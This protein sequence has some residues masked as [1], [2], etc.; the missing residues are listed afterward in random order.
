MYRET[1]ETKVKIQ[2]ANE[3]KVNTGIGFFDHMLTL[4]CFQS[5]LQ[6]DIEAKGDLYVDN[7]HTME[8]VGIVL[9]QVIKEKLGDRIGI[10]R[11]GNAFVPMDETLA[12]VTLDISNRPFLVFNM[13]IANEDIEEFFRAVAFNMGIT[14]HINLQYGKNEHHKIEAVFKAFGRALKEAMAITGNSVSSTKG[15]L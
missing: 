7:H 15:V 12:Q 11:Y 1:K 8:D 2:F 13:D 6:L 10:N 9:G 3:T 5:G 14:L 4:F